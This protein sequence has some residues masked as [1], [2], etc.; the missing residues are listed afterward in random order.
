MP[1]AARP[2]GRDWL[3][4]LAAGAVLG[5]VLLGIG[6]R[7][8]M[9]LVAM[10]G[11]QPGIFTID[12]SVVVSLLG[13]VAGAVVAVIFLLAR[14]VSPRHSWLRGVAFWTICLAIVLRGIRPLS[15]FN[16]VIFLPL[17]V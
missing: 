8:G 5:L 2:R 3:A 13:A 7:I 12:G 11:G 16:V 4:G 6:G 9:R 10:H 14:A 1:S 15:V 17:F